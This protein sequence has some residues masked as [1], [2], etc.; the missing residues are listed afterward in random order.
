M[1]SAVL[2]N[3]ISHT[4]RVRVAVGSGDQT[5]LPQRKSRAFDVCGNYSGCMVKII[6]RHDGSKFL[7]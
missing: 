5:L 2:V 3:L 1:S 4:G 7:S 6:L